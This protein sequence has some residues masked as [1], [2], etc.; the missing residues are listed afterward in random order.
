MDQLN[1]VKTMTVRFKKVRDFDRLRMMQ[2]F[3]RD[4]MKDDIED[5]YQIDNMDVDV[6]PD[7]IKEYGVVEGY[8][9]A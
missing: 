3:E 9:S 8:M 7:D 6:D 5:I 2:D 4:L 1:G